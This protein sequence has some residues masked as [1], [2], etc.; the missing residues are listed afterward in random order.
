M[1]FRR[2]PAKVIT[3]RDFKKFYNKSFINS[4]QSV[5]SDPHA[6]YNICDPD[7]FF[8]DTSKSA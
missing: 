2:L 3:Y 1:D 8:S 4:L 6:D 7:I 5:L